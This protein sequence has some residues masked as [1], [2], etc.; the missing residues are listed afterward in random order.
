MSRVAKRLSGSAA[1]GDF[2]IGIDRFKGTANIQPLKE[3][4]DLIMLGSW[5]RDL[6]VGGSSID[7]IDGSTSGDKFLLGARPVRIDNSNA[8]LSGFT[9]ANGAT[10]VVNFIYFCRVSNAGISVTPKVV[11]GTSM[12]DLVT[13]ATISGAF[14]CTATGDDYTGSFQVQ[15]VSLT[16]PSGAKWFLPICTIG[17]L[18]AEGYQ[19]FVDVQHN[20][21]IQ[22]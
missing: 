15:T 22:S 14:A 1:G 19:A 11:Y 17:G 20:R 4:I 13:V 8:Q 12:S 3:Q 18:P 16:L 10:L 2:N 9:D 21:Y 7:G 6:P 5:C